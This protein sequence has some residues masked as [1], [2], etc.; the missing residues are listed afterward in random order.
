M[1][2]EAQ[3]KK[4]MK[5]TYRDASVWIN[6]NP[7]MQ[8]GIITDASAWK[9]KLRRAWQDRKNLGRKKKININTALKKE[10]TTLVGV[11]EILAERTINYRDAHGAFKSIEEVMKVPGISAT[12]FGRIKD[13]VK[14]E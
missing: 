10:L 8:R 12:T 9:A 6:G 11:G 14:V 4:D 7:V 3:F 13:T 5:L 2:T 1:K